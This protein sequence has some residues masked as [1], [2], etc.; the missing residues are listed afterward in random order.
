MSSKNLTETTNPFDYYQDGDNVKINYGQHDG[1]YGIVYDTPENGKFHG[2]KDHS[3]NHLGYYHES[4]LDPDS[5]D[6]NFNA[7]DQG[8]TSDNTAGE[9]GSEFSNVDRYSSAGIGGTGISTYESFRNIIK[10]TIYEDVNGDDDDGD[11]HQSEADDFPDTSNIN[12]GNGINSNGSIINDEPENFKKDTGEGVE[13]VMSENVIPF[14]KKSSYEDAFSKQHND[15]HRHGVGWIECKYCG[16]KN[17]DYDCDE[18]QADGFNESYLKE[19]GEG[20]AV[21]CVG[22]GAIAGVGVNNPSI[23][24]PT[25]GEPGV[26]LKKSKYRAANVLLGLVKRKMSKGLI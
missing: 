23:P 25:Q 13:D 19:D 17:C 9:G 12:T 10:S 5:E 2:V 6:H 18:S 7:E 24:I 1:K 20:G 11:G 21:N 15:E 14:K 4:D 26:N 8:F 22:G 16:D 3:G